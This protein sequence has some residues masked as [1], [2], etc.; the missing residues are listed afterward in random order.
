MKRIAL[1]ADRVAVVHYTLRKR[2]YVSELTTDVAAFQDGACL[3]SGWR[4]DD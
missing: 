2:R 4:L 1:V 3:R